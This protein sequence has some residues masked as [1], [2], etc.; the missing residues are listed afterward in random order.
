VGLDLPS[1]RRNRRLKDRTGRTVAKLEKAALAKTPAGRAN[2]L[3]DA[4]FDEFLEN[5]GLDE[6]AHFLV[7][8]GLGRGEPQTRVETWLRKAL[9]YRRR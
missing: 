1:R 3:T 5:A 4:I 7:E 9:K 2:Y 8:M 6:I